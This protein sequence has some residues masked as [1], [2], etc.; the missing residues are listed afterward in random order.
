[1]NQRSLFVF[2]VLVFVGVGGTAGWASNIAWFGWNVDADAGLIARLTSQGHT[3]T[4][5]YP[6]GTVANGASQVA[7]ANSSDLVIISES[8]GSTAVSTGAGGTFY[9][10][11]VTTPIIS[12]EAYMFDEAK[13]AG[14]AG[15]VD[16][17]TTGRAAAPVPVQSPSDTL[18]ITD[19]LNPMAG[20]FPAGAVQV[21]TRLLGVNYITAPGSE[22]HVVAAA[23]ADGTYPSLVY[24]PVGAH[25][26]DGSVTPGLRVA[27][28]LGQ[29]INA[30]FQFG[31]I[32]TNGLNLFDAAVNYA[33]IPEPITAALLGF[34]GLALIRRKR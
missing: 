12:F 32:S 16:F 28:W 25:L 4:S 6:D 7:L 29:D 9:M 31:D 14:G 22:A 27:L 2:L 11:D 13:W 21:Y 33:L 5:F 34:G 23:L 10:K 18:Y 30:N 8:I 24:Y 20:G 15:G 1:M 3:V 26:I 17:G 19:P